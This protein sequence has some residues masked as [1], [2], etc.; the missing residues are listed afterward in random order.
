MVG[1]SSMTR[2]F[3]PAMLGDVS[4]LK[5]TSPGV[6]E[7]AALMLAAL[8]GGTAA[9]LTGA[10]RQRVEG[11]GLRVEKLGIR[12]VI[13]P[14]IEKEVNHGESFVKLR[15]MYQGMILKNSRRD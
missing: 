7:D 13:L 12:D 3:S 4:G 11:H 9:D 14:A 2:I 5:A 6:A 8:E 15:Q 1:L 10:L